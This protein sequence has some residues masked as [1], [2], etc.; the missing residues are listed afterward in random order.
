MSLMSLRTETTR[1]SKSLSWF[2]QH[3]AGAFG[4]ETGRQD[5]ADHGL[6]RRVAACCRP[7]CRGRRSGPE[8]RRDGSAGQN[9]CR[10]D[11]QP[12]PSRADFL[13]ADLSSLQETRQLAAA[14]LAGIRARH[15]HQ[16]CRDRIA[17]AGAGAAHQRRRPRIALC[18]QLP[19][20][21]SAG[22]PAA[23]LAEGSAPSRI[24][25]VASLGSNRSTSTT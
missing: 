18:R 23:A 5:G 2:A 12:G 3:E 7:A 6:D 22:A 17:D 15:L 10:R 13:S 19:F 21:I 11:P 8:P 9:P 24:V 25:N 4:D 1:I 14:I 20:G 16:Q